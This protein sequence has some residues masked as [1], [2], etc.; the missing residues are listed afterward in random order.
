MTMR[1][2]VIS[3]YDALSVDKQEQ[4][5]NFIEMLGNEVTD[6]SEYEDKL[7]QALRK[8]KEAFDRNPEV[9]SSEEVEADLMNRFGWEK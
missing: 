7:K 5:M 2:K 3:R 4:V 8:R 1:E 9:V 6:G